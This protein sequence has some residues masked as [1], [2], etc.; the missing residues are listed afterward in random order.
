MD[1]PLTNI[2]SK[3]S[4]VHCLRDVGTEGGEAYAAG[5]FEKNM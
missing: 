2:Y 1:N 3:L 4:L 5:R